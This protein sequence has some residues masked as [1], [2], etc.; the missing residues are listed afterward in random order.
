MIT[1]RPPGLSA[2][3]IARVIFIRSVGVFTM[4]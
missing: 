1:S 4:S 2:S 3:N